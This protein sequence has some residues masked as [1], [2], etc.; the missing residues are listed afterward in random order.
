[1]TGR[2]HWHDAVAA[3]ER[4]TAGDLRTLRLVAQLPLIWEGAI[5]CLYG[6][7]GGASVYRCLARLREMELIDR[8]HQALRPGRNPG[9]LY[10]TDLGVAALARIES[11]QVCRSRSR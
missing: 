4:L 5:E 2:H 6:L 3:A 7:R 1:V 8:T 10:L 9:L 11:P